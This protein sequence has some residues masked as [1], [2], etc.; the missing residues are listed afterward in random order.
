MKRIIRALLASYFRTSDKDVVQNGAVTVGGSKKLLNW[1]DDNIF[2]VDIY[3]ID[4]RK[5]KDAYAL[6][7]VSGSQVLSL[8]YSVMSYFERATAKQS[9]NTDLMNLTYSMLDYEEAFEGLGLK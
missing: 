6:S 8:D 9:G 3:N 5:V 2:Y 1:V 4:I 7:F